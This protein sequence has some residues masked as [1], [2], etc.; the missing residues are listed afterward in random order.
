MFKKLTFPILILAII[1]QLLLPVGMIGYSIKTGND[2][3][4]LGTEYKLSVEVSWAEDDTVYLYPKY[5]FR[6]MQY[7]IISVDEDGKAYFSDYSG[8]RPENGDYIRTDENT[9]RLLESIKIDYDNPSYVY[10]N[11]EGYLLVKVYNGNILPLELYIEDTPADDWLR[12]YWEDVMSYEDEMVDFD[13][14]SSFGVDDD[15]NL[16]DDPDVDATASDDEILWEP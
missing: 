5:L 3:K 2:V 10:L 7:A 4:N 9:R 16:F 6:Y 8:E 13:D 15:V 12:Q 14:Y 11:K 1:L